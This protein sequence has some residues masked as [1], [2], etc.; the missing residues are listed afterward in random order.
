MFEMIETSDKHFKI[1]CKLLFTGWP[2]V[3]KIFSRF[4]VLKSINYIWKDAV[5][6]LELCLA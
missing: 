2:F 3:W 5:I 4:I 1:W 6:L